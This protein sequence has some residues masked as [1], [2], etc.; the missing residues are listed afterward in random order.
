MAEEQDGELTCSH[1]NIKNT[2]TSG[3]MRTE[4]LLNAGRWPQTSERARKLPCNW[5]GQKE[6]EKERNR[7]A[8]CAPGREL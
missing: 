1:K 6:K 5:V 4:R 2:P 3:T 7:D 8:A